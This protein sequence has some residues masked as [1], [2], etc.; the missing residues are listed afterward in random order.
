MRITSPATMLLPLAV[1]SA[2]CSKSVPATDRA[3]MP[4]NEPGSEIVAVFV[5]S[6]GFQ[7]SSFHGNKGQPYL[8]GV[9]IIDTETASG[10]QSHGAQLLC[11]RPGSA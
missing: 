2:A 10:R 6:A 8:G 1:L 11:E 3:P 7:P 5:G 4:L 9:R